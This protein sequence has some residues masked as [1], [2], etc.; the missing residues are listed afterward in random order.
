MARD[1]GFKIQGSGFKFQDSKRKVWKCVLRKKVPD[2]RKSKHVSTI[3][4]LWRFYFTQK[5][6]LSY[7]GAVHKNFLSVACH[8]FGIVE[9]RT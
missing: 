1:S 4:L 9:I 3:V 6:P 7:A 2:F 5:F 8:T